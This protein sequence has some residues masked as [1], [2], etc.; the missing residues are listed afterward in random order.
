MAYFIL[1]QEVFG[2]GSHQI[3]MWIEAECLN[4]MK[5]ESVG[6]FS[7][8]LNIFHFILFIHG[9]VDRT[10]GFVHAREVSTTELN[11]PANFILFLM[12]VI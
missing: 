5:Q 6:W 3:R 10:Q 8:S 4:K 9:A 2:K 12:L 1:S 11:L 7:L